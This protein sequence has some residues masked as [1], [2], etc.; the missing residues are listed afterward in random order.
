VLDLHCAWCST[1]RR[2]RL[3]S[4]AQE[5]VNRVLA[6]VDLRV[7]RRTAIGNDFHANVER[8]LGRRPDVVFDVGANVGQTLASSRRA[9]PQ[10]RVVCFEPSS[11]PLAELRRAVD[12]DPLAEAHQIA[13]SDVE[14]DLELHEFEV[15]T[16][17]SL[18]NPVI[19]ASS[20]DFLRTGTTS[21]VHATTLDAWCTQHSVDKIDLLKIDTQG[22][23]ERVLVGA[24]GLLRA[25][26]VGLVYFEVIFA[27]H[28][29]AQQTFGSCE[30]LLAAHGYRF[31]DF[32][33]KVRG[34][35]G[36]MVYC[37]ALFVAE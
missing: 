28:Y 16:A 34:A 9:W 31:V 22:A 26:K 1:A 6:P 21:V 5:L 20:P 24:D 15:S 14:G 17:N 4:I 23:D 29:V 8:L 2:L 30:A 32:Y 11:K 37:N 36:E 27:K 7:V 18:L 33:E 19:D 12:A 35:A 3:I 10:C 25:R 13:L